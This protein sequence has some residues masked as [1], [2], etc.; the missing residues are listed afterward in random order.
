[1]K[2]LTAATKRSNAQRIDGPGLVR[3]SEFEAMLCVAAECR[4][5]LIGC[6]PSELTVNGQ[7][8]GAAAGLFLHEFYMSISGGF[9]RKLEV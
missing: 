3:C 1:M 2:E 4:V 7:Q 5:T 6:P 9:C 8:T